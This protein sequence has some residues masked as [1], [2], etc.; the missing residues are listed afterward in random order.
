M[1]G[2]YVAKIQK[3]SDK[4][5]EDTVGEETEA[6]DKEKT[7]SVV[8]KVE[9]ISTQEIKSKTKGK[10]KAPEEEQKAEKRGRKRSRISIPPNAKTR[11]HG[12]KGPKK[13]KQVEKK[14]QSAKS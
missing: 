13:A 1:D 14:R 5:P 7:A 3:L 2:F 4:L 8:E 12:Y 10:K 6:P 11:G 9:K